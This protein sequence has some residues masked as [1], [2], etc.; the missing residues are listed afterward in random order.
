MRRCDNNYIYFRHSKRRFYDR[1]VRT[2]FS[3]IP[4]NCISYLNPFLLQFIKQKLS[5]L[6]H[7]IDRNRFITI[8]TKIFCQYPLVL[9]QFYP[10]NQN[11][12]KFKTLMY[13]INFIF[14]SFLLIS[15]KSEQY[16]YHAPLKYNDK[17]K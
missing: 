4:V 8:F 15:H 13:L 10:T 9:P 12:I 3:R 16:K 14:Y 7:S 6:L 5:N 1:Y 11:I 2:Y 17:Q